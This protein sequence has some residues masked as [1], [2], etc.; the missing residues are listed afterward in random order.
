MRY[1]PH[2]Y[3]QFSNI[4]RLLPKCRA[5]QGLRFCNK[6]TNWQSVRPTVVLD[7]SFLQGSKA[8]AIQEMSQ[9][10]R[11]LMP[12]ALFYELLSN[13]DDRAACFGKFHKQNNPVELI[14]HPG[15]MLM[16]EIQSHMP[17]GKP[18]L[19]SELVNFRFHI[20]LSS[21]DFVFTP[22]AASAV[23]QRAEELRSD[24][25]EFIDAARIT[26]TFFPGLLEGSDANRTIARNTAESAIA[27]DIDSLRDLYR[28]LSSPVGESSFPPAELIEVEWAIV[29]WLQ[30][31]LLFGLDNYCRYPH[32]IP[33][34][35][36]NK[37]Y[38]RLEHDVLDAQ[39]L[40][41]GVLEG[42]FATSEK[43]LKKWFHLLCPTGTLH[44]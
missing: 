34:T 11:L 4:P 30:I 40:T 16:R 38:E 27:G 41:L 33:D 35:S 17:S 13:S 29:R 7:K 23:R 14:G 39:Y 8:A 22:Q 24:V 37:I 3:D 5:S 18:S 42:S 26:P 20:G 43:K 12:E 10:H 1:A 36:S 6:L 25:S 2:R 44:G 28:Q 21:P 19:H 9:S 15:A 32:T 31:K